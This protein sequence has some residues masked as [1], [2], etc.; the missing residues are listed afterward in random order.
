MYSYVR[1]LVHV[2]LYDVQFKYENVHRVKMFHVFVSQACEGSPTT[3]TIA[4]TVVLLGVV[5]VS[6]DVPSHAHFYSHALHAHTHTL[7][8]VYKHT[9]TH[10]YACLCSR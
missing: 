10:A 3:R 7:S 6:L 4:Y 9:H 8:C 5:V 1:V 2:H